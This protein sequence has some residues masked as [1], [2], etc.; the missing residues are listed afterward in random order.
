MQFPTVVT[1][2]LSQVVALFLGFV[3]AIIGKVTPAIITLIVLLML[4]GHG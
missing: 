3:L 1:F 2:P 4:L